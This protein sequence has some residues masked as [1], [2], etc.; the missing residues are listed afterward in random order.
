MCRTEFVDYANKIRDYCNKL[1]EIGEIA[2]KPMIVFQKSFGI[3]SSQEIQIIA[4]G[5]IFIVDL[6]KG[7]E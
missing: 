2:T 4:I 7:K 1:S 6:L 5:K 3:L